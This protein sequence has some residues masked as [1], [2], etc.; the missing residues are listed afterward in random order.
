MAFETEYMKAFV[1]FSKTR[2]FDATFPSFLPMSSRT[3]SYSSG[4]NTALVSMRNP[5]SS[6]PSSAE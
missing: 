3:N 4:S 2:D 1:S 6:N 5:A